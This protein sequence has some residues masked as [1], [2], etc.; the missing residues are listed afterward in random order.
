M[1]YKDKDMKESL[2]SMNP[3]L[4][5]E[6]R[7][8]LW[9]DIQSQLNASRV[10]QKAQ[11]TTWEHIRPRA[12]AVA[13]ISALLFGAGSMTVVYADTAKPGDALFPID[14]ATEK[15][16]LFFA[17]GEEKANLKVRHAEERFAE[18]TELFTEVQTDSS[19]AAAKTVRTQPSASRTKNDN[20]RMMATEAT[21]ATGTPQMQTTSHEAEAQA[22]S[23][24]GRKTEKRM[25]DEEITR[26]F[27]HLE[28][29]FDTTVSHLKEQKEEL[30]ARGNEEAVKAIERVIKRMEGLAISHNEHLQE[31]EAHLKSRLGQNRREERIQREAAASMQVQA[32]YSQKTASS[33]SQK[34]MDNSE[35]T[36]AAKASTTQTSKISAPLPKDSEEDEVQNKKDNVSKKREAREAVRTQKDTRSY[37]RKR[38]NEKKE[39]ILRERP[40][41]RERVLDGDSP[42]QNRERIREDD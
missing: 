3:Q 28:I 22:P 10:D 18:M 35:S 8:M 2:D 19:V 16:A 6:K 34:K 29:T 20:V 23:S 36:Q 32:G 27:A 38:I 41:L 40:D 11:N 26:E 15:V 7:A 14:R 1:R 17:Q 25:D 21:S 4:S 13:L 39:R 24:S 31:L 42:F 33:V 12:I 9:S 37:I 5:H 30:A